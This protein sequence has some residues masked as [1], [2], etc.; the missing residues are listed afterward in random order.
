MPCESNGKRKTLAR[1]KRGADDH[2][3][4]MY[5]LKNLVCLPRIWYHQS[6]SVR[7]CAE[8]TPNRH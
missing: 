8:A 5:F 2:P 6:V 3:N 1:P 4:A 7:K